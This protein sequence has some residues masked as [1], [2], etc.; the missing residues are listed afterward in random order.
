M[1][2]LDE[3]RQAEQRLIARVRELEPLAREYAELVDE[4]RGRGI[5]VGVGAST[6]I[7]PAPF[8][9][10]TPVGVAPA[11]APSVAPVDDPATQPP[12]PIGR[13]G[14]SAKAAPKRKASRAKTAKSTRPSKRGARAEQILA[15]VRDRPG[16][17]VKELA[18]ELEVE[19]SSLYQP[20]RK[21]VS[22]GALRKDGLELHVGEG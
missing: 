13:P 10:A 8:A 16:L 22:S 11:P 2:I 6:S 18:E 20:V 1:T 14:K 7:P 21:L 9:D 3:F 12:S 17:T 15:L 4:L 19:V 5:D